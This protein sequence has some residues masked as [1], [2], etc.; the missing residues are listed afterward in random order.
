MV[1]YATGFNAW[2]QLHF[3]R[4]RDEDDRE[5][6]DIS[7]FTCVLQDDDIDE[8]RP[9]FSYTRVHDGD[10][11]FYQY[12]SI[13]HLLANNPSHTFP[14]FPDITQ[15]VAFETGFAA[16]S[17]F[18][19]VWTWGD[20]RYTACLGREPSDDSPADTPNP[21]TDLDDLPTGPI[22]KLAAGGYLLAA[23]TAGHDLYCWG[24]AGRSRILADL[25][26]TPSPVVIYNDNDNDDD[27]NNDNNDNDG[28]QQQQQEEEEKE[29]EEED[30]VDVAIGEAHMLALTAAGR[31]Y[32]VGDNG[33]GQLGLPGRASAW[34]WT[35][36]DLGAESG[37]VIG[38]AAGPRNSFLVVRNT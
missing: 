3:E 35:R 4:P 5:P 23:L 17:S 21:V 19:R 2:G 18:G 16:L 1:L 24:D 10:H 25:S 14:N 33:N 38:V 30:V 28:Q 34:S 29:K 11:T 26:D 13:R 20:E 37:Q 31:V 22:V 8:I 15:L 9:F 27:D 36:V 32:V 12:P 6:E 7:T